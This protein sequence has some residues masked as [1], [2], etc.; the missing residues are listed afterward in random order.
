[1]LDLQK[2]DNAFV[3]AN[4]RLNNHY[5]NLVYDSLIMIFKNKKVFITGI[6]RPA[7]TLRN[8]SR[9]LK[10]HVCFV[11]CLYLTAS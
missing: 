7:K 4:C 8:R 1:M 10:D 3:A 5:D 2:G 6:C 9:N 11:E